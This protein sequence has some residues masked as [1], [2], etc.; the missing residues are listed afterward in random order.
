MLSTIEGVCCWSLSLH[1]PS[2]ATWSQCQRNEKS[3]E[4]EKILQPAIPLL[5]GCRWEGKSVTTRN[6][7]NCSEFSLKHFVHRASIYGEWVRHPVSCRSNRLFLE[8]VCSSLAHHGNLRSGP[9]RRGEQAC[10]LSTTAQQKTVHLQRKRGVR[11]KE[12][13]STKGTLP[14]DIWHC[15][16]TLLVVTA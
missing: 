7:S 15:L 11:L 13:L 1:L 9:G 3:R 6:Y 8:A 12:G 5:L 2:T 14:W 10:W 16:E 4:R